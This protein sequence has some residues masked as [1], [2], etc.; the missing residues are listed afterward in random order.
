[1]KQLLD[2]GHFAY[3]SEPSPKNAIKPDWWNP[4]WIPITSDGSG[5]L[6]CLDLSP[7]AA[8]SVGQ[9]IDFDHE[10]T[11]RFVLASSFRDA[12]KTYL[13]EVLAG[14]YVYSDDYGR[15]MPL[16]EL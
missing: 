5:N 13:D 10:T 9:L 6:Q 1:M 8:G 12:L 3:P 16:D 14:G 4:R 15:L 2:Q 11:H 7:G